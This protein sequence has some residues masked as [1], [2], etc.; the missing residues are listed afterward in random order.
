MVR[1]FMQTPISLYDY[2]EEYKGKYKS[3]SQLVRVISESWFKDNMYCPF[4][5][6]EKIKSY[7]NNYPVADFF[8]NNCGEKFQLKSKKKTIGNIIVDGEYNKMIQAIYSYSVPNFFFMSYSPMFDYIIE[9]IIVPKEFILPGIIKKR[10]PLSQRAKR[11]GWT[12]CNISLK[13]IPYSGKI[14]LIKDKNV[15]PASH[16]LKNIQKV[17]YYRKIKNVDQRG[18][19]ADIL[20]ILMKI[21]KDIFTLKDVYNY[22]PYLKVLH[23][24]N[25]NIE[26]KIRQ[27]LQILRNNNV[28][29]F[30]GKGVYRK[31]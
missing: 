8:C 27:Q 25:N 31:L 17:S 9:L 18:W 28:I 1:K 15:I 13:E 24:Q 20:N 4:C 5:T 7:E 11:R 26:A 16:V 30:L 29:E 10:K 23:P 14:Y 22:I 19:L 21:N 12:G 3:K 6:N 2:Y